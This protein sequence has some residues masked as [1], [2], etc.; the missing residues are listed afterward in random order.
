M[1]RGYQKRAVDKRD[2]WRS[3]FEEQAKEDEVKT[4]MFEDR[5][6]EME[7]DQECQERYQQTE[8]NP[9]TPLGHHLTRYLTM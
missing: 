8:V 3:Q 7:E 6:Q 1:C 9:H 4:K 5:I 2:N